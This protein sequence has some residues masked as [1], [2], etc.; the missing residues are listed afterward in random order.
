M[1]RGSLVRGLFCGPALGYVGS[2]PAATLRVR[3]WGRVELDWVAC[4]R[5]K[6]RRPRMGGCPRPSDPCALVRL[7]WVRLAPR[8]GRSV[9]PGWAPVS[10]AGLSWVMV[11]G[12]RLSPDGRSMA[13]LWSNRVVTVGL[14][15]PLDF[16]SRGSI[17]VRWARLGWVGVSLVWLGGVIGLSSDRR[18]VGWVGLASLSLGWKGLRWVQWVRWAIWIE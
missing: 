1:G 15:L 18:S 14:W 10:S 16:R 11:V 4:G 13:W 3:G 7:G 6:F 12:V 17:G 5:W 2:L 9:V 8:G